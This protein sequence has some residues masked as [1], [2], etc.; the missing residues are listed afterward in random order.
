MA[1]ERDSLLEQLEM[2]EQWGWAGYPYPARHNVGNDTLLQSLRLSPHFRDIRK[3]TLQQL[4][5][6]A[7]VHHYRK[8]QVLFIQGDTNPTLYFVLSGQIK[9]YQLARDGRERI[10]NILGAGELTGAIA[11]CDGGTYLS[12]AE[13]YDD[14]TIALFQWDD[15]YTIARRDSDLF[16]GLLRFLAYRLRR[17]QADIHRLA[18]HSAT[19]RLAARLLHLA[20]AFGEVTN[21]GIKINLNVSRGELGALVGTSRETATRV[22]RQFEE[23]EIIQLDGTRVT[24]IKP[25]ILQ[26]L[27][28]D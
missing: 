7:T 6:I 27:S 14:A 24:V 26:T 12:S 11:F 4:A 17:A 23:D 22:L 16:C 28:E 25:F 8:N 10:D 9:V 19:A 18:L 21:D 13:I 1:V 5:D 3:S 20:D 2:T 15:F